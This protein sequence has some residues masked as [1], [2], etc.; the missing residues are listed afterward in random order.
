V[1]Y[2]IFMEIQNYLGCNKCQNVVCIQFGRRFGLFGG[3]VSVPSFE[4][5]VIRMTLTAN[6]PCV[7]PVCSL[8]V[9]Q[10]SLT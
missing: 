8:I 9:L 5:V 6:V 2:I 7:Q 1:P 4:R 10:N 3:D